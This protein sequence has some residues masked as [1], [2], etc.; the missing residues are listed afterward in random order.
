MF[1]LF[2]FLLIWLVLVAIFSFM[3]GLTAIMNVRYG[4][5]SFGTYVTTAVFLGV[6]AIVLIAVGGYALTVDWN[7][8]VSLLGETSSAIQF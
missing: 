5:T 1:P 4:L 3:A 6:I 7:Q 8:N 2:W